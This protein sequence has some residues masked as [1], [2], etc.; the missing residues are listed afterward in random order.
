MSSVQ[1]FENTLSLAQDRIDAVLASKIESFCE[2]ADYQW[3]PKRAPDNIEPSNFVFEM[4][5]FL[6]AYVDA[7]LIGLSDEIKTRAYQRALQRINLW[8][9]DTL[10]SRDVARYNE[11]A[12]MNVLADVTFVEQEVKRLGKVGLDHVFDEVKMVSAGASLS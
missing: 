7:V 12:L 11:F 6:T 4:I 5:T 8:F 3:M 2:L 10:T 9:M 1:A